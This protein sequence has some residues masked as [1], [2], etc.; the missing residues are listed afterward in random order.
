MREIV[1]NQRRRASNSKDVQESEKPK[2]HAAHD[3]AGDLHVVTESES[4][5]QL[6]AAEAFSEDSNEPAAGSDPEEPV[7]GQ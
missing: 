5:T 1:R 6:Y 4:F 3:L 7:A 2:Q